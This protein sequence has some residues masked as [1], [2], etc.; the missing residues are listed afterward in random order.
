MATRTPASSFRC[1]LCRT[2]ARIPNQT[3]RAVT[4]D[5]SPLPPPRVRPKHEGGLLARPVHVLRAGADILT[6]VVA[7]AETVDAAAERAEQRFGL[8]GPRIADD[9]RLAAAVR[10]VRHCRLEGHSFGEPQH[11][12]DRVGLGGIGPHATAAERRPERGIV[13][14]HDRV[15]PAAAIEEKDH[16]LVVIERG[17]GKHLHCRLQTDGP[18]AP[19]DTSARA[20]T[21][22]NSV[23]G[24]TGP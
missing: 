13:Q 24:A 5:G 3:P 7:A 4:G 1:S 12:R 14:G 20:P 15:E 10:Q 16:L 8:F 22:D 6:R 23:P 9:H 19:R 17:R 18:S 21:A 2:A 11:V